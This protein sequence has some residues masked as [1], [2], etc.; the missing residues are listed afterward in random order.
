MP[1][2]RTVRVAMALVAGQAALCAVIGWFTFG[3]S[4]DDRQRPDTV[5]PVAA[6]PVVIPTAGVRLPVAP[7]APTPAVERTKAS[8]SARPPSRAAKPPPDPP[9]EQEVRD[10]PEVTPPVEEQSPSTVVAPEP[11]VSSR[12]GPD[13]DLASGT[14][15]PSMTTQGPVEV[16]ATCSTEGAPG[17]TADDVPVVCLSGDDGV[18]GWQIN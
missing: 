14:P 15:T 18:L 1:V 2:R 17:L 9:V 4:H 11:T 10:A 12:P 3:S 6:A 13:P 16:G 5:S 7:P 8:P